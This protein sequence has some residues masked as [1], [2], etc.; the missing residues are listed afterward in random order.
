[1]S[2][3]WRAII[4]GGGAVVWTIGLWIA[5]RSGSLR[6]I[7]PI[8]LGFTFIVSMVVYFALS[9]KTLVALVLLFWVPLTVMCIPAARW[10]TTI[11]Q[12]AL[13]TVY[14][15]TMSSLGRS[16]RLY[17]EKF[18]AYPDDL[19]TLA[20]RG[21]FDSSLSPFEIVYVGGDSSVLAYQKEPCRAVKK[22]EPWGGPGERAEEDIPAARIIVLKDKNYAV[23]VDEPVFQRDYQWLLAGES[24]TQPAE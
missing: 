2:K 22:G 8:F 19:A 10:G 23:F 14:G 17:H 18:G 21:Y 5:F 9:K 11:R 13:R 12:S 6:H 3:T 20:R 7:L 4:A 15:S 1:M 24:T 16:L